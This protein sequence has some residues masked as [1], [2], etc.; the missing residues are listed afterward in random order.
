MAL[1]SPIAP[2]SSA[3]IRSSFAK[4]MTT[5]I[6]VTWRHAGGGGSFFPGSAAASSPTIGSSG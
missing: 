6:S 5:S 1:D 4:P 3:R 2:V